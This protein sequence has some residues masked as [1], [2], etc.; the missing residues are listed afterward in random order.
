MMVV[1]VVVVVRAERTEF[2]N[3]VRTSEHDI[4]RNG[5]LAEGLI[6]HADT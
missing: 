2:G 1:V 3:D 4:F 5:P 6:F